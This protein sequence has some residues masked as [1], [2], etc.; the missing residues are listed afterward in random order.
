MI[1]AG[2]SGRQAAT[3]CDNGVLVDSPRMQLFW[4]AQGASDC[5]AMFPCKQMGELPGELRGPHTRRVK[6]PAV[7]G[8]GHRLWAAQRRGPSVRVRL[9]MIALLLLEAPIPPVTALPLL[10]PAPPA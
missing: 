1:P 4:R 2:L 7:Y 3:P 9:P 6:G 8:A 5:S 10:S